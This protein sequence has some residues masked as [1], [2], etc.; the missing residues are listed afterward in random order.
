MGTL[1]PIEMTLVLIVLGVYAF[2]GYCMGRLFEKA[3]KPLWAGFVPIYNTVVM[4]EIAGKEMWWLLILL[5][6]PFVP[7]IGTVA[8]LVVWTLISIDFV[9]AYGK[10][11]GYGVALGLLSIIM[12]PVLSFSNVTYLGSG[13]SGVTHMR[14]DKN[15]W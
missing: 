6:V 5:G 4:L 13:G 7:V 8:S 14:D 10:S 3:G 2:Y 12:L 11:S 1:G 15:P 9:K